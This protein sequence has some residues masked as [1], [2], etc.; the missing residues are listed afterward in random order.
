MPLFSL[1]LSLSGFKKFWKLKYH[2]C[3]G[4]LYFQRV[5][6]FFGRGIF[7]AA[8]T[9][10]EK[11]RTIIFAASSALGFPSY[12]LIRGLSSGVPVSDS[13]INIRRRRFTGEIPFLYRTP[14]G[15]AR[16]YIHTLAPCHFR[17]KTGCNC[18]RVRA[19][20]YTRAQFPI[21]FAGI[22]LHQSQCLED[23]FPITAGRAQPRADFSHVFS[24][25]F[26][27]GRGRVWKQKLHRTF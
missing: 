9:P 25:F 16:E 8:T 22:T 5:I 17:D 6:G 2:G 21:N 18:W 13:H 4:T 23:K 11:N 26:S 1:S 14:A 10:W 24:F 12:F 3:A 20:E 19:R 27:N 7:L 15:A